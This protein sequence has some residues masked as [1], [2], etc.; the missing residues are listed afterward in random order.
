MPALSL[1]W[2]ATVGYIPVLASEGE[3]MEWVFSFLTGRLGQGVPCP[4]LLAEKNNAKRCCEVQQVT[5]GMLGA[6]VWRA[7]YS[8]Q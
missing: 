6:I 3:G 1:S 2:L 8:V 5:G 4:T 7:L